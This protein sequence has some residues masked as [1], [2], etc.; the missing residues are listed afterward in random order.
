MDVLDSRAAHRDLDAQLRRLDS[1]YV[2]C[3]TPNTSASN[4]TLY[5]LYL[6]DS[7]FFEIRS[8]VRAFIWHCIMYG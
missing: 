1:I 7:L 3:T 6:I 4:Q 2:F 5:V 8:S